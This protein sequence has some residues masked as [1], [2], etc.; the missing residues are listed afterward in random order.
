[1][2]RTDKR[3]GSAP[4]AS[5]V[6]KL[7]FFGAKARGTHD[8]GDDF[9]SGKSA[10][11][12]RT[13][14][15]APSAATD[16]DLE[17]AKLITQRKVSVTSPLQ[18]RTTH[19]A[20]IPSSISEK[21]MPLKLLVYCSEKDLSNARS[22]I[23]E[24][25]LSC[26]VIY[27][28]KLEDALKHFYH[29]AALRMF[30]CWDNPPSVDALSILQTMSEAVSFSRADV[31]VIL[32]SKKESATIDFGRRDELVT[33]GALD[34]VQYPF[35]PMLLM[36]RLERSINY[37]K[38][39]E[40]YFDM[41]E[42]CESEIDAEISKLKHAMRQKDV[43]VD[44]LRH[45]IK[46]LCFRIVLLD[47]ERK[48][49]ED[50]KN[51]LSQQLKEKEMEIE[52][53]RRA[54]ETDTEND[55]ES[56]KRKIEQAFETP[57]QSL[58]RSLEQLSS[59]TYD[60]AEL[61]NVLLGAIKSIGSSDLYAPQFQKLLTDSSL[62]SMTRSWIRQEFQQ[63]SQASSPQPQVPSA[64]SHLEHIAEEDEELDQEET[65]AQ[66]DPDANEPMDQ[67]E[68]EAGQQ[69]PEVESQGDG[70]DKPVDGGQSKESSPSK[71]SGKEQAPDARPPSRSVS[72]KQLEIQVPA[73]NEVLPFATPGHFDSNIRRTDYDVLS[74]EEDKLLD[75]IERIFEELNLIEKFNIERDA[76]RSMSARIRSNY[77]TN[78]Y[79]NFEHA[80]DVLHSCYLMLTTT[81][82]TEYLTYIDVFALAFA[83]ICHDL[84]HPGVNNAFLVNCQADVALTYNDQSVLENHHCYKA[85]VILRESGCNIAK[86]LTTN[87]MKEFRRIVISS[88][89]NTDMARHFELLA[90]FTTHVQTKPFSRDS[91]D[92]RILLVSMAL[93]TAD[94]GNVMRPPHVSRNWSERVMAEFLLQGDAEKVVGIPVSPYMDRNDTDPAKMTLNFLDFIAVPLVESVHSLLPEFRTAYENTRSNRS[95]WADI[96]KQTTPTLPVTFPVLDSM[97][98]GM[99]GSP[100]WNDTIL[101]GSKRQKSQANL[102]PADPQSI[103][104]RTTTT[105]ESPPPTPTSSRSSGW[106]PKLFWRIS[107]PRSHSNPS[108]P[109]PHAAGASPAKGSEKGRSGNGGKSSRDVRTEAS[110]SA[111]EN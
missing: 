102:Q 10:A 93:H 25:A 12:T 74:L 29:D 7:P 86:S 110:G 105:A 64:T 18:F 15:A 90:K 78:P 101:V 50:K 80:V 36:R 11:H 32:P 59:G 58:I 65:V 81:R 21:G 83:A 26:Q 95:L 8:G 46:L 55:V 48:L 79:H 60:Q 107:R 13:L 87:E 54:Q 94:L 66:A 62:D 37:F 6:D 45:K 111:N 34:V 41:N 68:D 73:P 44:D 89:L 19:T 57:V 52:L 96:H 85:F 75:L 108:E 20:N 4:I 72:T 104:V 109:T 76:L 27:T 38:A 70:T 77:H 51:M 35:H 16:D 23:D 2:R 17:F 98:I 97:K 67:Q 69:V 9:S 63:D 53:L 42:E 103:P 91:M 84:D 24:D 3:R 106:V 31:I 56:M 88:I 40:S 14:A 5:A 71:S 1:M 61:Q 82:I 92:D 99:Y 47:K 33:L 100:H 39:T 43:I 22:S 30:V 49:K 28:H